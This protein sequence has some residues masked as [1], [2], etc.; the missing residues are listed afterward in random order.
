MELKQNVFNYYLMAYIF[1]QLIHN[2]F[3][4]FMRQITVE[5]KV[6]L[7]LFLISGRGLQPHKPSPLEMSLIV[8]IT[9]I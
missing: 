2:N 5:K 8:S 4:R 7:N 1:L 9:Y 3:L 6:V